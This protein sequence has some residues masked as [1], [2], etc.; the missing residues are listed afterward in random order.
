M[1]SCWPAPPWAHICVVGGS[2]R[3]GRSGA[4]W[5]RTRPRCAAPACPE[6]VAAIRRQLPAGSDP[7]DLVFTGPGRGVVA[8]GIRTAL[9]RHNFRR[10]YRSAVAKLADPATRLRPTA[11]RVL[12]ALRA[13]GPQTTGELATELT[14]QAGPSD[15]P[16]SRLPLVSSL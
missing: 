5:S 6:V 3:S 15:R 11:A 10:T 8:R 16:P 9:S 12:R 13:D 4:P 14:Q 1:A 2:A 7:G